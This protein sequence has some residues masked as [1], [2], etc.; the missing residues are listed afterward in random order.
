MY[1]YKEGKL[2]NYGTFLFFKIS[3]SASTLRQNTYFVFPK[4]TNNSNHCR[5]SR[6]SL[7]YLGVQVKDLSYPFFLTVVV[8][9][10]VVDFA[11]FFSFDTK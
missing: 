9:I 8:V 4:V 2:K 1:T 6:K 10:V 5:T 11:P 3:E 7:M